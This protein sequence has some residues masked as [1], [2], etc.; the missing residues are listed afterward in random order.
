MSFVA[1]F[2][3]TSNVFGISILNLSSIFTA[4]YAYVGITLFS[5][6][7]GAKFG[8]PLATVIV[9]A[10]VL[11]TLFSGLGL[12]LIAVFGAIFSIK[13]KRRLSHVKNNVDDKK[14]LKHLLLLY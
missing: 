9:V 6:L 12:Q 5:V 8:R 11:L 7:L 10:G 14:D 4:V 1:V 2:V 3:D 13:I